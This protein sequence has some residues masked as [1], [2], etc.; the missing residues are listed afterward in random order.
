MYLEHASA[1]ALGLLAQARELTRVVLD[2]PVHAIRLLILGLRLK[3]EI[4]TTTTTTKKKTKN[5]V[6]LRGPK[7]KTAFD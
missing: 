4:I 6:K 1:L 5:S 3:K 2:L 7:N